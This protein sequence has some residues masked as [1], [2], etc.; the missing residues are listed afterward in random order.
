M[1]RVLLILIVL[2]SLFAAISVLADDGIPDNCEYAA[3]EA[4]RTL[5]ARYES[6]NQRLVLVDWR[7]GA[8]VRTLATGLA[9]TRIVA[10]SPSCRYLAVAVGHLESMDTMILDVVNGGEMGRVL[11]AHRQPHPVTWGPNDYVMVESRNGATLWHV[12][13]GRRYLLEFE[14]NKGMLRNFERIRWDAAA[15]RVYLNSATSS[16]GFEVY[17]LATGQEIREP[18][19]YQSQQGMGNGAIDS[20]SGFLSA[21]RCDNLTVDYRPQTREVVLIRDGQ[22][23]QILDRGLYLVYH[24]SFS[25]GCRFASA[26]VRQFNPEVDGY[27]TYLFD[28]SL[29][30]EREDTIFIWDLDMGERIAEFRN[31]Y[32]NHYTPAVLGWS[33]D[34]QWAF[35]KSSSGS[36]VVELET[37]Q[38]RILVLSKLPADSKYLFEGVYNAPDVYWDFSHGQV[39]VTGWMRILTFDLRTG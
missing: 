28:R 11:D 1:R 25:P 9:E 19:I 17:D 10:W 13:S 27:E 38:A 5:F 8:E 24:V 7:T 21:A 32:V 23:V 16:R 14:F 2:V 18:V 33:P 3:D 31:P 22:D 20:T 34:G 36:Y 12:P 37:R 6:Q 15:G 4:G 29:R 30:F 39:I 35:I 26:E